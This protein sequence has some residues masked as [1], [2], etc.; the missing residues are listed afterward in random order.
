MDGSLI[1]GCSGLAFHRTGEGDF[2]YKILNP[3]SIFTAEFT[4]LLVTLRYSGEV[5]Q[6]PKKCFW[7]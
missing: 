4:A 3:A 2:G 1:D 6:P 5:I 7:F